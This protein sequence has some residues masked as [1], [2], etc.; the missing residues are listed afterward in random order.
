MRRPTPWLVESVVVAEIFSGLRQ[1]QKA[2][3]EADL[4]HE[5]QRKEGPSSSLWMLAVVIAVIFFAFPTEG[6]S[7]F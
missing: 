7:G 3:Y 5:P 2:P 4:F 1:Y 6:T